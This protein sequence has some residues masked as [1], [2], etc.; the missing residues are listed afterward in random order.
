MGKSWIVLGASFSL[1]AACG[2]ASAFCAVFPVLAS[3]AVSSSLV[4]GTGGAASAA[5]G[6]ACAFHELVEDLGAQVVLRHVDVVEDV[7]VRMQA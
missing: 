7:Q 4:S 6:V 2:G 3:G 5:R 1:F